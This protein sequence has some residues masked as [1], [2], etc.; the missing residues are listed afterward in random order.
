MTV[1][2]FMETRLFA[3]DR[4]IKEE[5]MVIFLLQVTEACHGLHC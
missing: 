1:S 2:V 4:E 5:K 3:R